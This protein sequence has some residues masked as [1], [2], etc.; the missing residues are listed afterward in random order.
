MHTQSTY[1]A[2]QMCT[3]CVHSAGESNLQAH[4]LHLHTATR[5]F[6][7]AYSS[8]RPP[9]TS[10][11]ERSTTRW[12][13]RQRAAGGGR[14]RRVVAR[15]HV[16]IARY[17][18]DRWWCKRKAAKACCVCSG[19]AGPCAPAANAVLCAGKEIARAFDRVRTYHQKLTAQ[20]R[21]KI[22]VGS[23]RAEAA[24]GLNAR[25]KA[26][27]CSARLRAAQRVIRSNLA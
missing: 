11:D 5:G 23:A 21:R 17:E 4:P 27:H 7:R 1:I 22:S 12:P 15:N 24:R 3:Y 26:Q 19:K 9:T 6:W 2:R 20:V 18:G 10:S 14:G 16:S 8:S 13:E 25:S